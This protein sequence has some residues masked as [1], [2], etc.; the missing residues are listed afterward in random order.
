MIR[1]VL[2]NS[3]NIMYPLLAFFLFGSWF[4]F[5][6]MWVFRRNSTRLY[7]ELSRLAVDVPP[8]KANSCAGEKII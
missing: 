5:I 7:K 8:E 1:A 4:L 6:I 3:N 2:E